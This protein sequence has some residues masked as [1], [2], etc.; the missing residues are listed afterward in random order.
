MNYTNYE[1]NI[2]EHHS[3]V[4]IGWPFDEPVKNPGNLGGRPALE[5]LWNA[6][7]SQKCKWE[8]L[9]PSELQALI[10]SNKAKQACGKQVYKPH[11]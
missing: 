5:K 8:K 7:E 10:A 4:L 11:M 1:H 3:V 6:L 2:V 9:K